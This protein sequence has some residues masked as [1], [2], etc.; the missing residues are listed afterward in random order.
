MVQHLDKINVILYIC[1]PIL[2]IFCPFPDHGDYLNA[3][4]QKVA[5]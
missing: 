5:D 2:Y 1:S 3:E 4:Q